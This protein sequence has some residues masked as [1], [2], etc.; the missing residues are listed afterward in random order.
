[1]NHSHQIIKKINHSA[2]F[3]NAYVHVISH[4]S[5]NRHFHFNLRKHM[6]GKNNNTHKMFKKNTVTDRTLA[7]RMHLINIIIIHVFI[8]TL[9]IY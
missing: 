5:S 4:F 8:F 6:G 3:F 7:F 9:L 1:M 2:V